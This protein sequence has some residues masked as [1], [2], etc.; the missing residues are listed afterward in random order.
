M[1]THSFLATWV[2]GKASIRLLDVAQGLALP[3]STCLIND[4]FN[5]SAIAQL[6]RGV[7]G[8]VASKIKPDNFH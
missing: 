7:P 8:Q 1:A 6:E 4:A 5:V 2:A 3:G